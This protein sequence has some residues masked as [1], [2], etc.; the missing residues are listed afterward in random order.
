IPEL[1]EKRKQG[2]ADFG[3]MQ[4]VEFHESTLPDRLLEESAEGTPDMG[5]TL[6]VGSPRSPIRFCFYEKNYEQ[7]KKQNAPLGFMCGVKNRM[8]I[9]LRDDRAQNALRYLVDERDIGDLAYGIIHDKIRFLFCPRWDRFIGEGW[10]KIQLTTKPEPYS[11]ERSWRWFVNQCAP[12]VK[13]HLIRDVLHDTNLVNEAVQSAK[14]SPRHKAMLK[15]SGLDES[16]II[17]PELLV[18]AG[19]ECDEVEYPTDPEY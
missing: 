16:Q 17:L 12:T 2:L 6:T 11:D 10:E 9:R 1:I 5:A 3:R 8:E 14:L 13:Y 15:Q 7:A 4:S 18:T 19:K